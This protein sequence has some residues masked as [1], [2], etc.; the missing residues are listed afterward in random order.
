MKGGRFAV[1][2]NWSSVRFFAS[3]LTALVLMVVVA[4]RSDATLVCTGSCEPHYA[5]VCVI[6]NHPACPPRDTQTTPTKME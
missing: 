6:C 2:M 1:G 3:L 5:G 4:Q